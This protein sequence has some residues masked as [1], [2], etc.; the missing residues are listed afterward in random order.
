MVEVA[1]RALSPGINDPFT[2][3]SCIDRLGDN[4]AFLMHRHFPRTLYFDESGYLRLQLKSVNFQG[5]VDASFNQIRQ[6]GK[7]D[8]AVIIKLLMT[9]VTLSKQVKNK[10]QALAIRNQAEAIIS[11]SNQIGGAEKDQQETEQ[12]YQKIISRLSD[13]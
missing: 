11:V 4:I 7:S 5:I 1:V 9:L 2:A 3:I 13:F 8:N 12:Q 10:E 6:H